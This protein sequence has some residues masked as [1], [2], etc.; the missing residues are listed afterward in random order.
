MKTSKEI[1]L[2][3]NKE[4]LDLD[5]VREYKAYQLELDSNEALKQLEKN[6]KKLQKEIVKKRYN[7]DSDIDSYIENYESLK[8]QFDSHPIVI[9]YMFCIQEV[10]DILQNINLKINNE[11][12]MIDNLD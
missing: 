3:L 12:K 1:A 4:I 8:K 9:N 5:I 2:C 10:D 7:K 6:L 11:I